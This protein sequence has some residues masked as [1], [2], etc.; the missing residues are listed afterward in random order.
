[1]LVVSP[2]SRNPNPTTGPMISSDR[3]DHTSML[4]FLETLFC[5]EAPN[6]TQWR[7]DTVGDLTSAFNFAGG[8]QGFDATTLPATDETDVTRM[9][10]LNAP[11]E[12]EGNHG[13]FPYPVAARVPRPVQE[14]LTGTVKRPSG[15]VLAAQCVPGNLPHP[16]TVGGA[17]PNTST[18]A[19]PGLAA[20]EVAAGVALLAASW[21]ARRRSA[22]PPDEVVLS[23]P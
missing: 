23:G 3:F 11:S 12:T 5:I 22:A 21:L 16:A 2:F 20:V 7:R 19:P 9:E 15:Q 14:E 13:T 8:A 1:M 18:P 4:R 17:S 6:L 10:C